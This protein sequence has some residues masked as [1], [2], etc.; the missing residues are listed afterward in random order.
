MET[1]YDVR[2]R[3]WGEAYEDSKPTMFAISSCGRGNAS[4][5]SVSTKRR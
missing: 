5:P 2:F 3:E 1:E 4:P